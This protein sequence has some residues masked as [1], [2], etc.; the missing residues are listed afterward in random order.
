MKIAILGYSEAGLTLILDILESQ[1]EIYEIF[2][3]NN[4]N[5]KEQ[6]H[7]NSTKIDFRIQENL[8]SEFDGGYLIGAINVDNKIKIFTNY[9]FLKNSFINILHSS[10]IV[11][12]TSVL[13]KGCILNAGTIIAGQ[14][15]LGNFVYLNR[16]VSVGHHTKIG[17]FTTVNP[18]CNIA[19]NVSI[20]VGCQIG[21]GSNIIDGL[22]I[23][24]NC[25]IGA[26]SL[27]LKNLPDNTVAYGNP[28]KVVRENKPLQP[29]FSH[30]V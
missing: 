19:G 4:L 9:D 20:G 23:G 16:K 21:M 17:D 26:G 12:N 22:T 29:G 2:V 13:G 28:C 25:I 6:K 30:S 18:G 1:N 3:V 14:T 7:V 8:P 15:R 10:A 5:I 24:N 11:A 27:V